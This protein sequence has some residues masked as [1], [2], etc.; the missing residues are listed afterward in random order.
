[1]ESKSKRNA[2][3]KPADL[4]EDLAGIEKRLAGDTAMPSDA[5]RMSYCGDVSHF[6]YRGN[7]GKTLSQAF[8]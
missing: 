1:M 6:Q 7:R 5:L 3:E 4:P 2:S 8:F